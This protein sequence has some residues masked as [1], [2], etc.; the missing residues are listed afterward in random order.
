MSDNASTDGTSEICLR[1]ARQ[2]HRI[3]YIRQTRNIG[4]VPNHIFVLQQ[5]R[6]ELFKS[7]AHDDLYARGPVGAL[8][9][10]ARR[11]STRR[12]GTRLV[13]R[14]RQ[15]R[16]RG[17][18]VRTRSGTRRTAS[19]GQVPQRPLR[20]LPRLRVRGDPHP[21]PATHEAPG[22]LPPR[23]S[24]DECRTRPA[25]RLS[26]GGGVAVL[27]PGT[28][29]TPDQRMCANAA[30]PWTRGAPTVC[31]IRSS[32]STAST[33]GRM[34]TAIRRAPLSTAERCE[35]FG[36]LTRYLAS[37]AVRQ[38]LYEDPLSTA[39]SIPVDMIV[40]GRAAR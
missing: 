3:R 9:P 7:A 17:R 31:A 6:G 15:L 29:G 11:G 22:E 20:G 38:R 35:C 16:R 2:D 12:A 18:H 8:R 40:A 21:G 33:C 37:R 30:R 26:T 36:I 27:P 10:R 19:G 23:R 34:W 1:Y 39:P 28:S 14:G 5:A 24:D 4:L 13:G 25:R 32:A